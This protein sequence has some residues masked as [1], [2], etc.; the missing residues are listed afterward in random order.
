MLLRD[1]L[2]RVMGV[3]YSAMKSAKWDDRI[4]LNGVSTPVDRRTAT[5]DTVTFLPKEAQPVY[6][7]KPCPIP[8]HVVWEDEWLMV[9]DKPAPLASQSSLGHPDDSL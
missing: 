2:R 7:L 3:S 4:L 9:V 6:T 1:V 8:V 5:G